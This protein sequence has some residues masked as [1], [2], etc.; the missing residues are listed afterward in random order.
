MYY[1]VKGEIAERAENLLVVDCGGVGYELNATAGCVSAYKVGDTAKIYTYLSV[2]DDDMRLFGFLDKKEKE[3]FLSLIS[4]SGIGPK[5]AMSVLSGMELNALILSVGKGDV[6]TLSK[7]KGLGKKTAE[8]IVL[9]LKDKVG[10]DLSQEASDSD[11]DFVGFISNGANEE[12]VQALLT[13]GYS[14]S[15]AE[16]KV[17][18]V[19]RDGM[20]VEQIIFDALKKG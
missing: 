10:M 6:K 1:Y 9:E 3:F 12:A 4:V 5:L 20:S 19:Q 18:A 13:F 11:A 2:T 7:I 8:R 17:L 16:R 15:D 14:R